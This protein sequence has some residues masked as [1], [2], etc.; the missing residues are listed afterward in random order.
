MGAAF[1]PM[2]RPPSWEKHR[3]SPLPGSSRRLAIRRE[4]RAFGLKTCK[5]FSGSGGIIWTEAR[6]AT[7]NLCCLVFS[8]VSVRNASKPVLVNNLKRDKRKVMIR[9]LPSHRALQKG[10]GL[11]TIVAIAVTSLATITSGQSMRTAANKSTSTPEWFLSR[12]HA[13]RW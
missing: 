6:N 7:D 2:Q 13:P 5:K 3:R 10:T 1:L 8:T 4:G 9:S 11:L 12:R